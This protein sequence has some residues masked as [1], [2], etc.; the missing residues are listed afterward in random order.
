MRK[1]IVLD[2]DDIKQIISERYGVEKKNIIKT[3]YS[4]TVI[5]NDEE[6]EDDG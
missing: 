1:A 2:S 5:F 4:F 3:Q 6:E